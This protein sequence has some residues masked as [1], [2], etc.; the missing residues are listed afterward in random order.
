M[1]TS[2]QTRSY[3]KIDHCLLNHF[4]KIKFFDGLG[5]RQK[6]LADV[7]A[8]MNSLQKEHLPAKTR[9]HLKKTLAEKGREK[10]EQGIRGALSNLRGAA[11]EILCNADSL[12]RGDIELKR[13]EKIS[14]Q[15]RHQ[16]DMALKKPESGVDYESKDGNLRIDKAI[17]AKWYTIPDKTIYLND[18]STA[19]VDGLNWPILEIW[20][21]AEKVDSDIAKK[22]NVTVV[23]R[24]SLND[25]W[26]AQFLCDI[27]NVIKGSKVETPTRLLPRPYQEPAILDC[28]T[29]FEQYDRG[30]VNVPCGWG[31]TLLGLWVAEELNANKTLALCPS[32][33]LCGQIFKSWLLNSKKKNIKRIVVCS[34]DSVAEVDSIVSY[35]DEV[36]FTVVKT[37][38]ELKQLTEN[39]DEY[40]IIST[41]QSCP[42]VSEA[43]LEFDFCFFDEAHRTTQPNDQLF[44]HALFDANIKIKKR[45][46]VTATPRTVES[47]NSRCNTMDNEA[48]YG[49]VFFR[50]SF[51][52]AVHK[53]IISPVKI[54]TNKITTEDLD[55]ELI[56]HGITRVGWDVAQTR[57]V[58]CIVGFIKAITHLN[59]KKTFIYASR[60]DSAEVISGDTIMGIKQFAD[61][62][63]TFHVNGRMR[64]STRKREFTEF[65]KCEL[66]VMTNA[67]CLNEGVDCPVV[68]CVAFFNPRKSIIDII[69]SVGRAMRI[70]PQNPNKIGYIYV[71]IFEDLQENTN[72]ALYD[73]PYEVLVDVIRAMASH[74][75]SLNNLLNTFLGD[76]TD[77]GGGAFPPIFEVIDGDNVD[78]NQLL[79]EIVSKITP[80]F[81]RA[82]WS[83]W[84]QNIGIAKALK[85]KFGHVNLHEIFGGNIE[86]V[87][88]RL[89]LSEDSLITPEFK[90]WVVNK[91][92][93]KNA[94]TVSQRKD[95]EDLDF[96]FEPAKARWKIVTKLLSNV[97][98]DYG[99]LEEESGIN[100]HAAFSHADKWSEG[101]FVPVQAPPDL[102]DI[103]MRYSTDENSKKL[104]KFER[105]AS[106]WLNALVK[107]YES[108][109]KDKP[110]D[111]DFK[112]IPINCYSSEY[113]HEWQMN[114]LK[115]IGWIPVRGEDV[116]D[117]KLI[118][119]IEDCLQEGSRD[120]GTRNKK[121]G[122]NRWS[123]ASKPNRR[124]IR[125]EEKTGKI[126]FPSTF[127]YKGVNL[128]RIIAG[129]FKTHYNTQNSM[130]TKAKV[131]GVI[132][133]DDMETMIKGVTLLAFKRTQKL[134]KRFE[135]LGILTLSE[136]M[137]AT[138]WKLDLENWIQVSSG[139]TK[140]EEDIHFAHH[141]E[142]LVREQEH[143]G[144]LS[145]E[146]KILLQKAGLTINKITS[147]EEK[148]QSKI[149]HNIA[150]LKKMAQ[151][152]GHV[153]SYGLRRN[154]KGKVV[155]EAKFK[156][157]KDRER[158]NAIQGL[159][160]YKID[161][162]LS[163]KDIKTIG[164]LPYWVWNKEEATTALFSE[165][166]NLC[167]IWF[168]ENPNKKYMPLH[169][170]VTNPYPFELP[171]SL[172]EGKSFDTGN[173]LH[174]LRMITEGDGKRIIMPWQLRILNQE[175]GNKWKKTSSDKK[176]LTIS[177]TTARPSNHQKRA[178]L[179]RLGTKAHSEKG[180]RRLVVQLSFSEEK[181][182]EKALAVLQRYIDKNPNYNP[183]DLKNDFNKGKFN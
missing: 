140:D 145:K 103:A 114:F 132:T 52:S 41:Y 176:V 155:P 10:Y 13:G 160:Q 79:Q 112:H 156:N 35:E 48:V 56:K 116:K 107:Q 38:E 94:L 141:F 154:W 57:M 2:N 139:K 46:F 32:K 67:R 26:N 98:K 83:Q 90:R 74:D 47:K 9:K 150:V 119:L 133:S 44:A 21:N 20:T 113:L 95:L 100:W 22:K 92:K 175:L 108:T 177:R 82:R 109:I 158:Y 183:Q 127:I 19:L 49:P 117:D 142:E 181:L 8:M 120:K 29:G 40:Q 25:R 159:V 76:P 88:S 58:A 136:K 28:I 148:R 124:Y 180:K 63:K 149:A 24:E 11:G 115:E 75:D 161:G 30:Q 169:T 5:S 157:E 118:A 86:T 128:G 37:V 138:V 182:A 15:K 110:T 16:Y 42:K 130:Q 78:L 143:S 70:D 173:F 1:V 146:Q 36:D 71:P 105:M 121:R 137:E 17:Q 97:L 73:S 59:I 43:G 6:S 153:R 170:K 85:E 61:K 125:A 123:W 18:I 60:V 72:D 87:K 111:E 104:E 163:R 101:H 23:S 7:E 53:G 131:L 162:H 12:L 171:H 99:S 172:N 66:A 135:A 174:R 50:E 152:L 96:E 54:I 93:H 179:I 147:T 68:D 14:R 122:Q 89:C 151:E 34:D 84:S 164:D 102:V 144:K 81:R 39:C 167:K 126:I 51:A 62:I 134:I 27:K 33:D 80:I 106:K 64:A 165:K 168:E 31:K 91:I 178:F 69:Q 166:V 77:N 65:L 45:L 129:R 55:R 3:P 4:N